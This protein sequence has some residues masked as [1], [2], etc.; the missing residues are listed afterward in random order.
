MSIILKPR[1]TRSAAR[2]QG[3]S[4]LSGRGLATILTGGAV[5]LALILAM[6]IPA[7]ADMRFRKVLRCVMIKAP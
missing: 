7:K 2:G 3:A 4:T 1:T 5:V 6:A